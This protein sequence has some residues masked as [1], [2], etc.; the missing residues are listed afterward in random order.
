M[1]KEMKRFAVTG[2]AAAC[3]VGMMAAPVYAGE[4]GDRLIENE[5]E[6]ME[7]IQK[8]GTLTL[9]TTD[10]YNYLDGSNYSISRYTDNPSS[11]DLRNVDGKNYVTPVKFQNPWGTC[12]G[13]AAIA[14]SE[15]SIISEMGLNPDE[16]DLSELQI[17]WFAANALPEDN[18]DYPSQRGEGTTVTD[19]HPLNIGG[20]LYTATSVISSG[21]GPVGESLIPYRGAEG[22][23]QYRSSGEPYCY[24][25]DDDWSVDES[26][27]F[28][29]AIELE[30][31]SVL[32]NP[33]L[34]EN[35]ENGN[36]YY[37]YNESGTNAIKAELMAGRAVS[38]GFCAD[39][40]R[41]PQDKEEKSKREPKYINADT[42]A[43]YTYETVWANHAVTIVGWDDN[44][45]ASNFLEGHQPPADGAWIVKNSWG[46][47]SNEFP[48]KNNWGNEGYFYL[49][50]YDQSLAVPETFNYDIDS[51]NSGD[52]GYY[53]IDQYDLMPSSEVLVDVYEE[54][55]RMANVFTASEN[56]IL[57]AVSTETAT[58]GTTVTY[59]IYSLNDEYENPRDGEL[60]MTFE[61]T[62]EY[63]GYHR[64]ELDH[65]C[66]IPAGEAYSIVVTLE[67][68]DGTYGMLAYYDMGKEYSEE[69][70]WD[71]YTTGIVNAGE[72][73]YCTQGQWT[74][75]HD[76]LE[77]LRQ[78]NIANGKKNYWSYDNFAI[79]GYADPTEAPVMTVSQEILNPAD[80]YY[81]GDTITYL[82]SVTNTS[83]AS[84]SALL[85]SSL[86]DLGEKAQTIIRAGDTLTFSYDYIVQEADAEAG[87]VDNTLSVTL[88]KDSN[89]TPVTTTTSA[90][91]GTRPKMIEGDGSKW[92][93][94][95]KTTI[96]FRSDAAY[97][98]FI[99]VRIDGRTISPSTY[100]VK[101]KEGS[102]VV[103]L[104]YGY[105]Q[106]L[107]IGTHRIGIVS[108]NGTAEGSF[109][110][111]FESS[112]L[113]KKAELFEKY[114]GKYWPSTW[115]RNV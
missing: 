82:V 53:L 55:S 47:A 26:N 23:I 63:G 81:P 7:Q 30:E 19:G 54:E 2:L 86:V 20:M 108:Q 77:N 60:L 97:T 1:Y 62:Y 84:V 67:H 33:A 3:A 68:P 61:R 58:P 48:H 29:Q 83:E 27:R 72:S 14:A 12:W 8:C 73:L 89:F 74:D 96:S 111:S 22:K 18:E 64:E 66:L 101:E 6:L 109:Q 93:K 103:T 79:K 70:G 85:S 43:H 57:R 113:Q 112:Y 71:Y 10:A 42:W 49:S 11:F 4:F 51:F 102:T 90:V 110:V 87:S 35:D 80:V 34:W 95:S 38:I 21:I 99:E 100:T 104:R 115:N 98:D 78:Q 65:G 114:F 94:E 39:T 69:Y 28:A 44:Y 40:Y 17:A 24:S 52:A 75:L 88:P 56:Q 50:Y 13:F 36:T 32:P 9:R 59:E 46:A 31:S 37:V 106:T 45:A 15:T 16:V 25:E 92:T 41:P 91:I 5:S 107:R 76:D 105:L